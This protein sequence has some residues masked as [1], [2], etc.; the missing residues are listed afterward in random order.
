MSAA[1]IIY[2]IKKSRL[3]QVLASLFDIYINSNIENIVRKV[4]RYQRVLRR[5]IIVNR[6]DKSTKQKHTMVIKAKP[7]ESKIEKYE[8]H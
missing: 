2:Q 3:N 4:C 7:Q 5:R 8:P 6:M 1:I